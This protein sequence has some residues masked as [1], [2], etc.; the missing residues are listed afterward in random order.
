MPG[1]SKKDGV[2]SRAVEWARLHRL[3]V[4][5]VWDA[6]AQLEGQYMDWA[7][8]IGGVGSRRVGLRGEYHSLPGDRRR[9]AFRQGRA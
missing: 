9:Q 5:G 1:E 7:V 4:A 8:A 2:G 3:P 6:A